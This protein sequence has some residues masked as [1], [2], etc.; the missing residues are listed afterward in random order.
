[1]NRIEATK[2]KGSIVLVDMGQEG[3]YYGRLEE[4][5]TPPKKTWSG[6]VFITGVAEVPDL[7]ASHMLSEM[8]DAYVTVPGSKIF[9]I[10][11]EEGLTYTESVRH[12]IQ[13]VINQLIEKT[14]ANEEAAR[15]WAEIGSVYGEVV[16]PKAFEDE[17]TPTDP[18]PYVYYRIRK[19]DE[20]LPYLEEEVSMDVLE[21]E[22]CPF[23]FEIERKGTWVPVSHVSEFIFQTEKGKEYKV[24]ER[25][26]V[27]IHTEQFQ[28]FTILL[29]ELEHPARESLLH[30]IETYG[31]TIE[32][33]ANCHNRLLYELLQADGLTSFK[34]VN[35][36]TLQRPGRT[37]FIQHH[38][39]RT[40]HEHHPDYV[41]DRFECTSDDGERQISTYT[42]AVPKDHEA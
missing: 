10:D 26:Y 37:L 18:E 19:D 25:E 40:L 6:K 21:L 16:L 3:M 8:K 4:V 34:G 35:F 23:E 13:S 33:L 9:A 12:S 27:R 42:N 28:P 22:G 17:A 1:M 31:F 41:Y 36:I 20:G 29:N 15:K 2:R 32:N 30:H 38:Y 14:A 5:L 24:K 11:V 39:E 7:E